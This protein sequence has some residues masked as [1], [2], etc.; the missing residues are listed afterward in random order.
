MK[1]VKIAELKAHL[2]E[3]IKDV[4]RGRELTVMERTT[5]VAR[6]V[7]CGTDST[8]LDVRPPRRRVPRLQDVE[9][10][11]ALTI[12]GDIV[13]LLLEERGEDR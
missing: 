10:P 13:D 12:E 3:Y 7:P 11:P 5:P 1:S 6:I 9:L 4:R 8:M 2:S